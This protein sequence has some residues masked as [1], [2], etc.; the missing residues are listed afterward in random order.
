ML[1]SRGHRVER[2]SCIYAVLL[3]TI[4]FQVLK[5]VLQIVPS[6]PR[7]RQI[8]VDFEKAMWSL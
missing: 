2:C 1:S 6:M 7:V 5:M 8:T 4:L 3:N